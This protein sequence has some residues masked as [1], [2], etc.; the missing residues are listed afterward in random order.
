[1]RKPSKI[2]KT[3]IVLILAALLSL[4]TLLSAK[5]AIVVDVNDRPYY[6]HGPG[7]YVGPRYYVWVPG[8]WGWRHHHRVW[9]HGHYA[10]R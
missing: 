6:I 4:G 5:A 8:N 2:M 1:M 7:Y 9:I 3:K 10:V